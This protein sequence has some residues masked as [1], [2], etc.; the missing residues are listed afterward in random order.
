M[1]TYFYGINNGDDEYEATVA[2]ATTGK[3]VE[4]VVNSSANVPSREELLLAVE[5]LEN[6]ILRQNYAP[7]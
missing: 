3:D 6:F 7:V 5:K 4:V 2:A 1:A